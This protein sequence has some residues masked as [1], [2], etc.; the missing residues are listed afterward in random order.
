MS[1]DK[2]LRE[3]LSEEGH[4]RTPPLPDLQRLIGGGR[5]RKRRRTVA[6]VSMALAAVVLVG[7]TAY[8]L[9]QAD[10]LGAGEK[11]DAVDQPP[12]AAGRAPVEPGTHAYL[13]G[14]TSLGARIDFDVALEG[15]GWFAADLPLLYD[16]EHAAGAGAYRPESVATDSACSNNWQGTSASRT[17][18]GLARQLTE[19][20]NGTVLQQPTPTTV[21]GHPA[22]HLGMRIS[23]PCPVPAYYA[24][25]RSQ[26]VDRG[27]TYTDSASDISIEFWVVDLDGTTVVVDQWHEVD[28]PQDL[29]DRAASARESIEFLPAD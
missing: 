4:S 28:A 3:M 6:R 21:L 22:L 1:L 23:I 7:G 27:I 9:G 26:V 10:L 20:P 19:L 15:S 18:R 13:A 2:Q 16:G 24:L 5:A 25:A 17:P 14:F 11:P 12:V 29:V 8:G